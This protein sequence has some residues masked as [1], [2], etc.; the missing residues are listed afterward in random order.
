MSLF[1]YLKRSKAARLFLLLLLLCSCATTAT[2][3]TAPDTSRK[4]ETRT[5]AAPFCE[6]YTASA[7]TLLELCY[8]ISQKDWDAGLLSGVNNRERCID[9]Y[10][11]CKTDRSKRIFSLAPDDISI[12]V[13]CKDE[14]S[15][16]VTVTTDNSEV[17]GRFWPLIEGHITG[18][19]AGEACPPS[20]PK[21]MPTHES[22]PAIDKQ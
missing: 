17:F 1:A 4:T 9:Y 18:K 15:S 8:T 5:I 7:S 19:R 20:M 22:K 14:K 16:I 6:T 2:E 10:A 13:S 12:S 21:P 3:T 11:D